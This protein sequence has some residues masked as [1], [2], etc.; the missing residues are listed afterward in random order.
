VVAR[1]AKAEFAFEIENLYAVDVH[2]AGVRSSCGCT[3]PR[4]TKKTLTTYETGAIVASYNTGAFSGKRGATIT[5]T[6]DKPRY[7]E[8]QLTVGGYI[9]SDMVIQPGSLAFGSV[10]EGAPAEK[11]ARISYYGGKH[12]WSIVEVRGTDD[13]TE[14][15]LQPTRD[16]YGRSAYSLVARL[17]PGAP[18]GYFRNQLT[19]VTNDP[20]APKVPLI[21][22]GRVVAPVTLS[23]A[24]LLLGVM[25]PGQTVDKKLIIRAKEP[26]KVVAID[27]ES[28]C[29]QFKFD[30]QS[31]K[32]LHII[33]MTFTAG[34]TT[35]KVVETIN[36]RTSLGEGVT[37][38]C[39][40]SAA[41]VDGMVAK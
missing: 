38:Q 15:E 34:D 14:V 39:T 13:Y 29:F 25:H 8:V 35:A 23:P 31:E 28:D 10:E 19:L 26:F 3:T 27:A 40:A 2:I 4:I 20:T 41:V 24:T 36:V 11:T 18:A 6:F 16:S 7:A 33:P 32:K 5:V 30:E 9:R 22:E 12:N 17:K 21:M 1:N 37:A